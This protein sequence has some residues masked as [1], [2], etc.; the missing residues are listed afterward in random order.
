MK[1]FKRKRR[2][3]TRKNYGTSFQSSST[4]GNYS[5]TSTEQ[6]LFKWLP[7]VSIKMEVASGLDRVTDRI[8]KGPLVPFSRGGGGGGGL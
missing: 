5:P 4:T 1:A 7:V 8:N 2:K 6:S 3:K